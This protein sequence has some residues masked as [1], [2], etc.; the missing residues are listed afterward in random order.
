MLFFGEELTL[1][2]HLLKIYCLK[3]EAQERL[4]TSEY[5]AHGR[6]LSVFFFF[7]G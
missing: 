6:L 3:V 5:P 1:H 7:T 4:I 2:V